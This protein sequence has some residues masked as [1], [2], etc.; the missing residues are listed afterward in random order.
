MT[1]CIMW[2]VCGRWGV[3]G[4]RWGAR[5]CDAGA[6]GVIRF[7]AGLLRCELKRC[8]QHVLKILCRI[9]KRI[10]TDF[11]FQMYDG[12]A[13]SSMMRSIISGARS[14]GSSTASIVHGGNRISFSLA[15]CERIDTSA[16]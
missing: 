14:D 16:P 7:D 9:S 3:R 2:L 12:T 1:V 11:S 6:A 10:S 13:S 4:R 8:V 5:A 15:N